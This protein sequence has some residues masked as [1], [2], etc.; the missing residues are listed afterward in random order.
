RHFVSDLLH[1][2]MI[3]VE[4][5]SIRLDGTVWPIRDVAPESQEISLGEL[6]V[7][8]SGVFTP[9]GS[10]L[11]ISIGA[12]IAGIEE[13]TGLPSGALAGLGH[14]PVA[15]AAT[16]ADVYMEAG[17]TISFDW[18][19]DNYD[20]TQRDDSAYVVLDGSPIALANGQDADDPGSAG[21]VHGSFTVAATGMHSLAFIVADGMADNGNVPR[22]FINHVVIA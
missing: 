14:D 22:L 1:L 6:P 17:Q 18:M 11:L 20:A 7:L 12:S 21:W 15:G 5:V 8:G 13:F 9:M 16:R 19:F 4:A 10:L 3:H 2:D